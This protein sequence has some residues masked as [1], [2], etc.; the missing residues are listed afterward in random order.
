[1]VKQPEAHFGAM[2]CEAKYKSLFLCIKDLMD[3]AGKLQI[4]FEVIGSFLSSP[5]TSTSFQSA[6]CPLLGALLRGRS[7]IL[8]LEPVRG[9]LRASSTFLVKGFQKGEENLR[10]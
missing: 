9:H 8:A 2:Q 10:R 3:I 6:T 1:M 7:T 5:L 4:C